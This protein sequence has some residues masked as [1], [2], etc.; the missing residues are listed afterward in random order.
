MLEIT[1]RGTYSEMGAEIG[2]LLRKNNYKPPP[3]AKDRFELAKRCEKALEE[4]APTLLE[5]LN[6]MVEAGGYADTHLKVFELALNPY[7]EFG[8]SIFAVSDE[9]TSTG[10]VIFARNYDWERSF[11]DLF[12]LFRTYPKGALASISCTDLLVG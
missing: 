8:C 12:T 2:K 9:H 11:H 1:V 6:A 5:E 7:P 3:I 10:K 4:H